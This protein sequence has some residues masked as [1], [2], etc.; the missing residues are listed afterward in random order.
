MESMRASLGV[1]ICLMFITHKPQEVLASAHRR[2]HYRLPWATDLRS[3][4]T[5]A[6]LGA[7]VL[8]KRA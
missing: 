8:L 2:Q 3:G 7:G 1:L 5:W 4:L 6:K